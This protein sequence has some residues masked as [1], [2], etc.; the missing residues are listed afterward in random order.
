MKRMNVRLR[1]PKTLRKWADGSLWREL[2]LTIIATTIS[3]VLTF[4]TV[5]WLEHRQRI[6]D[7][8]MSALMVISN[9]DK[10]TNELNRQAVLMSHRDSI[11]TWIL[12]LPIDSLDMIPIEEMTGP[13]N[14]VLRFDILAHDK[15][16]ESIFSNSIE[17]WKNMGNFQFLD[18]VGECFSEM[19][20]D[21]EYCNNWVKD[22]EQAVSEVIEHPENH[23]GEHTH[24]KLLSNEVIRQKLENIH[25]RQY[26]LEYARDH[27]RYMNELNMKYIGITKADVE[28][29]TNSN[30]KVVT[31]DNEPT[32]SDYRKPMLSPD[33]LYTVKAEADRIR[34]IL[35][36][37][38]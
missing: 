14:E 27:L 15:T 22:F 37:A 23:P 35:M 38:K 29:F 12:S 9:I 3:I 1:M 21:E 16:A 18:K 2:L 6:N 19:N 32:V 17:T 34:A 24:T 20:T 31:N 13:I 30:T 36:N 10:F 7:R 25:P 26:W 33:S 4:G 28:A 8:K 5:A 11:A